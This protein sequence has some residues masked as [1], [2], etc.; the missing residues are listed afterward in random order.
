MEF[1]E[2]RAKKP[3]I[4]FV[5]FWQAFKTWRRQ[6]ASRRVLDNLSDEQLKDVGIKRSDYC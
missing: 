1:D 2:N 5:F 6:A 4:G 3:F